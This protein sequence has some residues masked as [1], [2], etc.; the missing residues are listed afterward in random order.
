[1]T[2][3]NEM[4]LEDDTFLS[5]DRTFK[6]FRQVQSSG[7][8]GLRPGRDDGP[9]SGIAATPSQSKRNSL[10][11]DTLFQSTNVTVHQYGSGLTSSHEDL[12]PP[13]LSKYSKYLCAIKFS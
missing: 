10:G 1:M 3:R 12:S 6:S 4:A 11:N 2:S 7:G 9:S 8:Q 5:I 13:N